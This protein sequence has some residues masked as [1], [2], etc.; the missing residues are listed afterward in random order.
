MKKTILTFV[1]VTLVL[2]LAIF[3]AVS[4]VSAQKAET[5]VLADTLAEPVVY[6]RGWSGTGGTCYGSGTCDGSMDQTRLQQRLQDGTGENCQNPEGCTLQQNRYGWS[7]DGAGQ[8]FQFGNQGAEACPNGGTCSMDQ[9]Q[10]RQQLRD[11]SCGMK[12]GTGTGT[13]TRSGRGN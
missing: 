3:G 1:I 9:T 8:Q 4:A 10:T 2:G 5:G 12:P 11:G 7:E 13:R 6:R